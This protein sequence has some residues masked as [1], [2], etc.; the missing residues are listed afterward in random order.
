MT[1]YNIIKSQ[2]ESKRRAEERKRE[3]LA[4]VEK[5]RLRQEYYEKSRKEHEELRRRELEREVQTRPAIDKKKVEDEMRKRRAWDIKIKKPE[6]VVPES[7]TPLAK[8]LVSRKAVELPE[9]RR[10]DVGW[11]RHKTPEGN[12]VEGGDSMSS[13]ESAAPSLDLSVAAGLPVSLSIGQRGVRVELVGGNQ[14]MKGAEADLIV[15]MSDSKGKSIKPKLEP[16]RARIDPKGNQRFSVTFDVPDEAARGP[17]SF[18]AYIKESAFYLDHESGK[19]EPVLLSSQLKTSLDLQYRKGS[20]EVKEIDGAR[21][22]GLSFNN[23]GESGGLVS[24]KSRLIVSGES[25][26]EAPINLENE[27]KVKGL[28]KNITLLFPY[29]KETAPIKMVVMLVGVDSNGKPY[30]K[31]QEIKA[32]KDK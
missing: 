13:N 26:D 7:T 21:F 5:E 12:A 30:E 8:P 16:S 24:K 15:S 6:P 29:G 23:T 20:A 3:Q 18:E 9:E 27:R 19:S 25:G 1:C 11:R 14:S 10:G 32:E 22:L 31:R 2:E 4:Q 28:E 17:L